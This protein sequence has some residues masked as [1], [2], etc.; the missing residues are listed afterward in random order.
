M[1]FQYALTW[2]LDSLL[3]PSLMLHMYGFVL[4]LFGS[5]WLASITCGDP[6]Q[7]IFSKAASYLVCIYVI[8]EICLG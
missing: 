8:V 1:T 7:L 3:Q 2:T 6:S 4:A 5:L